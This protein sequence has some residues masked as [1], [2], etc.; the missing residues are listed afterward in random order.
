MNGKFLHFIVAVFL[1]IWFWSDS[2]IIVIAVMSP[3]LWFTFGLLWI[4][5]GVTIS[6]IFSRQFHSNYKNMVS[7][8]GKVIVKLLLS[9]GIPYPAKSHQPLNPKAQY[10][11]VTVT[12]IGGKLFQ[13]CNEKLF[14]WQWLQGIIVL[15]PSS[16]HI[17]TFHWSI[18]PQCSSLVQQKSVI[19]QLNSMAHEC[20]KVREG[21]YHLV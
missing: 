13:D 18:Y 12:Q 6:D 11:A 5:Q 7:N 17:P 3:K 20:T 4:Y 16:K 1:I 15:F 9:D 10:I 21:H 8:F 14:V 19:I 2:A